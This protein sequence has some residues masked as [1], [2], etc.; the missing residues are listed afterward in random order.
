[1]RKIFLLLML[2]IPYYALSKSWSGTG[3]ALSNGYVVTNF[4]VVDGAD[5]IVIHETENSTSYVAHVVNFDKKNDLAILH[6]SDNSFSGYGQIPYS[7]R[8]SL[9]E[10]G[11]KVWALG[12]PMTD[13]M[14][15]EIKFTDGVISSKSGTNGDISYYQMTVPIQP[16]NSGGPLFDAKGNISGI[17]SAGL[18]RE[19]FSTEN[20]NY[21]IKISYLL[22]LI[23]SSSLAEVLPHGC[24]L[25]KLP[26]TDA[27]KIAKNYV[28]Y[29]T[30]EGVKTNKGNTNLIKKEGFEFPHLYCDLPDF[31]PVDLGLSV[32]WASCNL[33]VNKPYLYGED[34]QYGMTE[35][36]WLSGKYPYAD[37]NFAKLREKLVN[38]TLPLELDP[39]YLQLGEG[40]RMPTAFE[41]RELYTKCTWSFVF[42]EVNGMNYGC[43]LVVGP[44]GNYI[45]LKTDIK[46]ANFYMSSTAANDVN[47]CYVI[48]T[49]VAPYN[50][51]VNRVEFGSRVATASLKYYIR[52][53]YTK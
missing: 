15:N 39:A 36:T 28:Y 1:M 7:I 6:V 16:G 46:S 31:E 51:Q 42:I 34:Y 33:G 47:G 21:S 29:I 27:I 23:E 37:K 26:V 13:V 30:C 40:W 19:L 44:N 3:F 43:F 53:V 50:G 12:F 5:S 9:L 25:N 22:N 49:S 18:N 32:K 20:V 17:T 2:L 4:H 10:V 24:E 38:N 41:L 11:E 48:H 45:I 52:P 35:P 8:T 14:G